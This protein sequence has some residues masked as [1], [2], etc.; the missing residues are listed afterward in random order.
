VTLSAAN[1]PGEEALHATVLVELILG[2]A[3][4][5]TLALVDDQFDVSASGPA[6]LDERRALINRNDRIAVAVQHQQ[7]GRRQAIREVDRRSVAVRLD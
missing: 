1:V 6:A 3:K 7:R 4:A 5:V 2:L